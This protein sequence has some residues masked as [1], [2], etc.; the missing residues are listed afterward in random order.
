VKKKPKKISL[1]KLRRLKD[2][3]NPRKRMAHFRLTEDEYARLYEL[4]AETKREASDIIREG[5]M[6]HID[7]A[8]NAI[9]AS[10][11]PPAA[12]LWRKKSRITKG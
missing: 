8:L 11:T 12:G 4:C 1:K 7:A 9:R 6:A 10:D 3:L 2:L 5:L